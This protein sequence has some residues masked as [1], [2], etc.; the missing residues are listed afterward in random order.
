M[1]MYQG[2]PNLVAN[3]GV[4]TNEW[5][6]RNIIN[7]SDWRHGQKMIRI[8]LQEP[9]KRGTAWLQY[10]AAIQ[11]TTKQ[12]EA[13]VISLNFNGSPLKVDQWKRA[14]YSEYFQKSLKYYNPEYSP[15]KGSKQALAKMKQ[16]HIFLNISKHAQMMDSSFKIKILVE[17]GCNLCL[18][19]MQTP[20]TAD[21]QLQ[22]HTM[23]FLPM[24][25]EDMTRGEH[26]L[27]V[28]ECYWWA[29]DVT[30]QR[31]LKLFRRGR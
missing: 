31:Q 17:E 27:P 18:K 11:H 16:L 25:L 4:A 19:N 23:V 15:S 2:D 7:Q 24:P 22:K 3:G 26:F 6:N 30:L 10:N 8:P 9:R 13:W 29:R 1:D 5:S 21:G 14:K 20:Q 28:K 12:M